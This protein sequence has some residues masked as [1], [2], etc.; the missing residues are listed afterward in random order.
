MSGFHQTGGDFEGSEQRSGPVPLIAVAEA[1]DR[2]IVGRPQIS[3]RPFECLN[4]WLFV[5]RK[6]QRIFRR[7][8]I[9]T[10]NVRGF[11]PEL[12][13][14]ADAP[15]AATFQTD[16]MLTQEAPHLM[17]AHI[18]QFPGQQFA[19][20]L[21]ITLW[22]FAVQ[23]FQ[24]AL[25]RFLLLIPG[26]FTGPRRVAE[27]RQALRRKAAS[28]FRNARRSRAKFR[29]DPI[30]AFSL[31]RQQN[32]PRPIYQPLFGLAIPAESCPCRREAEFLSP[33]APWIQ[34]S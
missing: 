21:S 7:I 3:L 16:I 20:P 13:I 24:N 23:Q 28:P 17:V 2:F 8:Q 4:G 26:R 6:Y 31:T 18:A 29:G 27:T 15:A 33:F 10:D 1:V 9:Q 30:V 12:R 14:G 22:R 34:P 19:V 5:H 32:D 25:L 11:G